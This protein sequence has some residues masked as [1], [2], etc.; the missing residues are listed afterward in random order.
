MVAIF[1]ALATPIATLSRL[2]IGQ[3]KMLQLLHS[4]HSIAGNCAW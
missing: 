2:P 4:P 3:C 1:L